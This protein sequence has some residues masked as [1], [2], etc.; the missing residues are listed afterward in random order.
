MV[1]AGL[2]E[3]VVEQAGLLVVMLSDLGQGFPSS[4]P[5]F[6]STPDNT[7]CLAFI[8]VANL[9]L[10]VDA[11]LAFAWQSLSAEQTRW[12]EVVKPTCS[13]AVLFGM[14]G[15]MWGLSV[16]TDCFST[17]KTGLVQTC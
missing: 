7:Q 2:L 14:R 5:G 6:E 16:L 12:F 8:F 4:Y 1:P 17:G 13:L 9:K 3:G 11:G 15:G 10:A